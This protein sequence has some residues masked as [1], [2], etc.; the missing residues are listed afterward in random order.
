MSTPFLYHSVEPEN[1]KATYNEYDNVDFV[2]NFEGRK[3]VCNTVRLEGSLR[4]A[5]NG[6]PLPLVQ[7][8]AGPP[9][10]VGGNIAKR[11]YIDPS[12]GIHS[13]VDSIQ[14]SVL[15]LGSVEN[16]NGYARYVGMTEDTTTNHNDMSNSENLSELKFPMLQM[17]PPVL[18]GEVARD[19]TGINNP[20][21]FSFKPQFILNT[22]AEVNGQGLGMSFNKTGTI[23]VVFSLARINDVLFGPD[24]DN[25]TSYELTNLRLVFTSIPEDGIKN[26]TVHKVKYHIKQSILSRTT[27]IS[28]NI[29]AKCSG[30]SCSFITQ[31]KENTEK[32]NSYNR[33]TYPDLQELQF[34]FNNNTN[35]YITYQIRDND[36]VLLRYLQSMGKMSKHSRTQLTE[37]AGKHSYGVGLDFQGMVDLSSQ[38]FNVVLNSNSDIQPMSIHLYFHSMI[39]V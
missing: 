7:P 19:N 33:E 4:V 25:D 22:A 24:V 39:Q 16:F 2:M 3:L 17:V 1:S 34:L 13:V 37:L 11:I 21:S 27:N 23:R 30:V 6:L 36:E 32:D 29:P 8:A 31:A 5:Y 18:H 35:E 28:S 15:T 12:I 9:A 20:N 38:T 10:V 14:T 26:N